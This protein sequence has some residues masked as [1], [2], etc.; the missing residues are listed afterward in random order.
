[1]KTYNLY[2]FPVAPVARQAN[3]MVGA[4]LGSTVNLAC[5]FHGYP[6]DNTSWHREIG[7]IHEYG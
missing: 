1:M 5:E 4:V 6:N 7:E 3:Q 2:T